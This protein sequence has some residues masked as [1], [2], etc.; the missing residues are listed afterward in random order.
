MAKEFKVGYKTRNKLQRAIQKVIRDEGLIQEYTLLN[1]VRIS[2]T[3]GDLNQLYVTINAVYY[4]MFL[5][6]GAELWNGGYIKP[7]DITEQALSSSLGRQFQQECVDAYIAWMLNEYPILEVGRIAVDKLSI[8]IKYNLFGDDG[9][10]WN[11]QFYKAS[12]I[13]VNWN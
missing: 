2:S 8:N 11:G 13:R 12:N 5:D 7:F 10:N 3:T 6:E 4:Y 1:S 9:G